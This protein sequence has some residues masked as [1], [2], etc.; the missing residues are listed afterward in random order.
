MALVVKDRVR[1][2]SIFSGTGTITLVGAVVGF[3]SFSVIGN[4]NTTYY[5][6][7]DSITG[8]WE[9]G[10][11]TYTAAGTTLSR[12]TILESSTGGTIVN[13]SAGVK[14]VFC[15]YP[16]ERSVY[17]DGTT[18]TP[19]TAATLP[20]VS[21]G[22]GATTAPDALTN[23]GA[24][25]GA[26]SSTDNAIARFDGTTGKIIE[27]SAVTIA[28]DGAT[29]IDVSSTT[30]ALRITQRGAGNA[31]LV[32]DSANPDATPFI[33]DA[34]GRALVGSGTSYAVGGA[35]GLLQITGTTN[36]HQSLSRFTTNTSEASF[37]FGK[38]RGSSP[39][40]LGIVASGDSLGTIGFS[41][42]DGIGFIRAASITAAVDGTPGTNDR[43]G[44]IVFSTTADGASTPTERMRIDSAG[45]LGIG[46]TAPA[47]YSIRSAK[48]VT[49]ATTAYGI[50]QEGI[51][52][53]DVTV[54]YNP[55]VTSVGTQ[56]AAFT[57]SSLRHFYANQTTFG[58]GSTV[59]NQ[60]GFFVESS[61]TGATNNYGFYSNIPAAA[62]RFN[63]YANGTATNYFAGN[64]IIDVTDNT[65]AALRITQ[66]GTGNALL[67]EDSTNPDST[68]FVVTAD[69]R[70]VVGDTQA[71]T[72][73]FLI[74]PS[75]S[76][77]G[78]SV[79]TTTAAIYDY[80]N[81]A[82]N[83]ASFVTQKSKSGT[84]GTQGIVASGD[85][86]FNASF[87]GSDGVNFI[88]AAAIDVYVD[89]TPG[90][91]DMP[92]RLVFSTT[93]DGAST[94]TER[95][96]ITNAGDVGIG[97]TTPTAKL[98]VAG[99][100]KDSAGNVRQ[101]P[102]SGAAKTTSYTLTTGDVGEFIQVGSGGS[103]TIP[104]A[105][106]AAGDAVSVFNNTSGDITITCTITTAYIAGTDADKATVTL[107][108]RGVCTIL[109]I[110]GTVCVISGTVS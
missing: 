69:G 102:Q 15:T 28:D 34:D 68:P 39:S 106:F 104:D 62:N 9:V 25:A 61:L 94:V 4:G 37:N 36:A 67:V 96:R 7:V 83:G 64:T 45:R 92:G 63:F 82:V 50:I 56:A 55:I 24:V 44:R 35:T 3:Q 30:N 17:V 99:S 29:V 31:L 49:G 5:A 12:D 26:A 52:Q 84:I 23:L 107:A 48:S 103:I 109:F 33:I 79:N 81:S 21:G 22:T 18:I 40:V 19:A 11:G 27:N 85:R 89:G 74:V 6:I 2:T 70:V 32:E 47:G 101:I 43:P 108:T 46:T 10:I 58:A 76:I 105:T 87:S 66:L 91:N 38:S 95:M 86:L 53:S 54:A 72:G 60:Y 57:L 93:A 110:S 80:S 98:D 90:T 100:I 78:T 1:E 51:V 97:T 59:T 16:A 71:R 13:F 42:D 8:A 75:F 14:D 41:G 20:I 73:A 65:N 77:V 88:T